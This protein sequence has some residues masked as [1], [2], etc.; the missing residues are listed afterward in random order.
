MSRDLEPARIGA[1][2]VNYRT[3]FAYAMG[4]AQAI[5]DAQERARHVA[6]VWFG[7]KFTTD[8]V[9]LA[10]GLTVHNSEG[11]PRPVWRCA[12]GEYEWACIC[13]CGVQVATPS[14]IDLHAV[15]RAWTAKRYGEAA[16]SR[17]EQVRAEAGQDR[18]LALN[19]LFRMDVNK[20]LA[21][22]WRGYE[23][24]WDCL[25]IY[26]LRVICERAQDLAGASA[27]STP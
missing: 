23:S 20:E 9:P 8:F 5:E 21:V 6:R 19:D 11:Y 1:H 18:R 7:F 22:K 12:T 27:S 3:L 10:E 4:A 16:V 17:A 24:R 26:L 15:V 2:D 25:N 14:D 13:V